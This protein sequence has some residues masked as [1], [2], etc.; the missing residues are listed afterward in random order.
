M[1]LDMK[2]YTKIPNELIEPCQIPVRARFLYEVLLKFAGNKD[3]CYPSHKTLAKYI[4]DCSTKNI[5]QLL[6][7][8]QKHRLITWTRRG[9]N[10]TN[11]YTITRE[12]N[13][14]WNGGSYHIGTKF[15]FHIRTK[16]PDKNTYIRGKDKK[17]LES[18]R[19]ILVAKGAY[20]HTGSFI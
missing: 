13:R 11:T 15:P 6:S 9:F 7:I 2:N 8:L 10:K 14:E 4:D 19:D 5:Q 20:D 3:T 12:F 16:V 1:Q 17:G 18:C